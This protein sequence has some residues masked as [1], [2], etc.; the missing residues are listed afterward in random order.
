[1]GII[2]LNKINFY[3]LNQYGRNVRRLNA[4]VNADAARYVA[5]IDD[6]G[7]NDARITNA[8]NGPNA[9]DAITTRIII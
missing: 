4:N 6:A 1:M 5:T 8:G 3:S 2:Y 9:N 7:T